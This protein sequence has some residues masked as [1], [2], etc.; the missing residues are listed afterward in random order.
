MIFL[1]TLLGDFC[2]NSFFLQAT[3]I[4][5]VTLKRNNCIYVRDTKLRATY[6]NQKH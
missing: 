6:Y 3:F 2:Q 4:F 1:N 5:L